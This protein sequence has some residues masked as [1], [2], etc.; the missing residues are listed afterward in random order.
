MSRYGD[1]SIRHR[2]EV[3]PECRS[4]AFRVIRVARKPIDDSTTEVKRKFRCLRCRKVVAVKT[5]VVETVVAP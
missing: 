4:G 1:T 5:Q 3:C 2:P